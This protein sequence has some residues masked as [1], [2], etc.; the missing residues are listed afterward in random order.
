M[1]SV[2]SEDM[3]KEIERVALVFAR[4]CLG[5]EDAKLDIPQVISPLRAHSPNYY[6]RYGFNCL[7][8]NQILEL[9]RDWC[10]NT[11][12]DFYVLNVT[13]YNP[14]PNVVDDIY[15]VTLRTNRKTFETKS[16]DLGCAL[17]SA[18][19]EAVREEQ[20]SN[21]SVTGEP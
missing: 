8:L 16:L 9:V 7:H 17:L 1:I 19:V 4:E 12:P 5:W 15:V 3:D 2:M 11:L 14:V 21:K 10:R 18:C 13:Y 20:R 6:G